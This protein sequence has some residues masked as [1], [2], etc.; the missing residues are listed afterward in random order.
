V[1][2]LHGVFKDSLGYIIS[3][4]T[5]LCELVSV[6]VQKPDVQKSSI[7]GFQMALCP[8]DVNKK[9]MLTVCF[10]CFSVPVLKET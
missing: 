5:R 9:L 4:G 10:S 7:Q 6:L 2:K 3:V 1:P 8:S